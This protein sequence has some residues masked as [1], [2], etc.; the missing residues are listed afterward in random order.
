PPPH[1]CTRT[2]HDAL[3]IFGESDITNVDLSN[4]AP[5]D[6]RS[7]TYEVTNEGSVSGDLTLG[8]EHHGGNTA[9]RDALQVQVG[10]LSSNSLTAYEKQGPASFGT[11]APGETK[12]IDV[13]VSLPETGEN[14]NALQGT[15]VSAKLTTTLTHEGES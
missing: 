9:L 15:D 1:C 2:L 13:T 6:Q 3:P 4:M 8:V 12:D 5:G 7:F 14:Q 10:S 11:V